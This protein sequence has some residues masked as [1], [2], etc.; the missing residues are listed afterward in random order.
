[1]PERSKN[2][3]KANVAGTDSKSKGP[4]VGMALGYSS[5]GKSVMGKKKRMVSGRWQGV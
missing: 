3:D 2:S 5:A 4:K 1:M